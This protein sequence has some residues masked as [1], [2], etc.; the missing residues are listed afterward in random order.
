MK[1]FNENQIKIIRE[2]YK[3]MTHTEYGEKLCYEFEADTEKTKKLHDLF[4]EIEENHGKKDRMHIEDII[5]EC[6]AE[7]DRQ[8]FIMGFLYCQRINGIS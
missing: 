1:E 5:S 7:S 4:D 2:L 6:S 3:T 8:H